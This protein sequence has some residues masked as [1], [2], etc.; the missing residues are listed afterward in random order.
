MKIQIFLFLG[1]FGIVSGQSASLLCQ[2]TERDPDDSD[3]ADNLICPFSSET[4]CI[5]GSQICDCVNKAILSEWGSGFVER[6]PRV[7]D[8]PA[9]YHYDP[10]YYYDDNFG[11]HSIDCRKSL[12]MLSSCSE[13]YRERDS[14][15]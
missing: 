2:G 12:N 13:F 6:F 8:D 3:P 10:S 14:G 5:N 1:F 9:S 11:V 7:F 4:D 15:S